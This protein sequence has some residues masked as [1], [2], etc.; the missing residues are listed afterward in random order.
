VSSGV[1]AE[2]ALPATVTAPRRRFYLT[3]AACLAVALLCA[4]SNLRPVGHSFKII[5]SMHT[6][7]APGG[8]V[9]MDLALFNPNSMGLSV[10]RITARLEGV[11]RGLGECN[12]DDF[13]IRQYSGDYALTVPSSSTPSLTD[14]GI[15]VAQWPQLSMVN[16][17]VNQ[18][19]CKNATIAISFTVEAHQVI[20]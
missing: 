3:I 1:A 6:L 10:T 18:N 17:P 11:S 8:T 5:G 13:R 19:G 9:P 12:L 7:I 20:P 4:V 15:D 14:L 2:P 16:L